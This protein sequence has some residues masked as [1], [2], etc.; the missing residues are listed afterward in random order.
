MGCDMIQIVFHRD[1]SGVSM[2]IGSKGEEI[3]SLR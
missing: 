3:E 2:G 1:N